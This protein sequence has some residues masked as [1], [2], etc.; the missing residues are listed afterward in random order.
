[1]VLVIEGVNKSR[2]RNRTERPAF[3]FLIDFDT[4][5]KNV[6]IIYDNKC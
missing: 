2:G 3:I 5:I 1:M 4:E 6:L